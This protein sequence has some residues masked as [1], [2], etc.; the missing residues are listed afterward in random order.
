MPRNHP[1]DSR[2]PDREGAGPVEAAE[3][4]KQARDPVAAVDP[5][6]VG[7]RKTR[8]VTDQA[9]AGASTL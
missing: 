3:A 9:A 6:E 2:I 5:A 1:V 7:E 4:V 8:R